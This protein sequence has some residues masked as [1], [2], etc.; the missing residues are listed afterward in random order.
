MVFLFH[1]RQI[2]WYCCGIDQDHLLPNPYLT[3]TYHFTLCAFGSG[4]IINCPN[5]H[6]A[7]FF[8]WRIRLMQDF[9]LYTIMERH[10]DPSPHPR[11]TY[12][13]SMALRVHVGP[14]P[15]SRPSSSHLFCAHVS[16]SLWYPSS[17][18]PASRCPSTLTLFFLHSYF[19][20]ATPHL[21]V[22]N[23]SFV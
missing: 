14:W 2:L 5:S 23:Y 10:V 3:I 22:H 6:S 16:S 15:P 7:G 17:S 8:G 13:Y 1:S 19:L 4:T 21:V 12:Y 11:P 20:L 9:F 18:G